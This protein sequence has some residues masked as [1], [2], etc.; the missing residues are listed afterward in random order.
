MK[1][2]LFLTLVFFLFSINYTNAQL[3]KFVKNVKSNVQK[4]LLGGQNQEQ[5]QNSGKKTLPEPASECADAT[6]ILDL[7]RK[8]K[9]DY[10][11]I[12][13]TSGDDGSILVQSHLDSK[14]YIVKDGDTK[15]PYAKGD[16][17]LDVFGVTSNDS[18]DQDFMLKYKE[19]FT[20]TGDKYLITFMD[21]KY[22]PF[23][24][25]NQFVVTK[26]RDKFA[27]I[28]TENMMVT[29]DR[30]K[31]MEAEMNN[32]KTDEEKMNLSMK[33]AQE[34]QSN[35]MGKGPASIAPKFITSVPE[36]TFDPL[37]SAGAKFSANFKYD[38]ILLY[39]YDRIIDLNG[40]TIFSVNQA[41]YNPEE[42]YISS[43][44]SRFASYNYGTITF[45]DKSTLS[46][47][48]NPHWL[49]ADGKLYLAYMYYSPKRNSIMQ[50]KIPF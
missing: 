45:N 47:V 34:M 14:Y 20:K 30:A 11:E 4:D 32:A 43:D 15:G 41:S 7:N 29:E 9:V 39:S 13:I 23:A 22:G 18:K 21:K 42:C 31:K 44:N 46:D 17:A 2:T 27:A 50:C 12:S 24:M 26:T 8:L 40:K 5:N 37:L 49:K 10:S 25:I 6:L 3:T 35:M 33:Y 19:Y 16:P 28:V 38:D 48:F 1:K 36:A